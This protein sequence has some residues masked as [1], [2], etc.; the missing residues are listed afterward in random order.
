MN[1]LLA[2]MWKNNAQEPLKQVKISG[3]FGWEDACIDNFNSFSV[4]Q[5]RKIKL[6]SMR[7][8]G[9]EIMGTETINGV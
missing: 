5:A 2:A 6:S 1:V 3:L 7:G 8:Q 9:W 4:V